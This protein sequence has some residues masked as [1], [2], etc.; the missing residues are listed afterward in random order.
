MLAVER[1]LIQQLPSIFPLD[2]VCDLSDTDTDRLVGESATMAMERA[3]VLEK[4]RVLEDGLAQ[5]TQLDKRPMSVVPE[6]HLQL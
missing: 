2:L 1:C 5:L 3:R 6:R 4:L